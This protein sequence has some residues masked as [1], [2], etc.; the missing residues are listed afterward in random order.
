VPR[1]P[2]ISRHV[3]HYKTKF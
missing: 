1:G 2:T 3:A